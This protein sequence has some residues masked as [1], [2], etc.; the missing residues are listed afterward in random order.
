MV[1]AA[2][3]GTTAISLASAWAYGE[4]KGWEHSL[5]K[6]LWEAPGC[7]RTLPPPSSG[8]L[9]RLR[10]RVHHASRFRGSD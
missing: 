8:G 6:K 9:H 4:V 1:N 5:H 2:V 3:L 10:G 7:V